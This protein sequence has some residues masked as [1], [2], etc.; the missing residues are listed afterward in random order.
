MRTQAK[1]FLKNLHSNKRI[2]WRAARVFLMFCIAISL[3]MV[4]FED[5]FIYIPAKYPEGL[6]DLAGSD[7]RGGESAFRIEDC[8][9]T[10]AD[11]V[12]L[13]GWYCTPPPP[14]DAETEAVLLWFH[15][16]AGNITYRYGMLAMLMKLPVSIFIVDYRGYG[17][18]EGSP[19]EAGLYLDATAAWDYLVNDRRVPPDRIIIFGKSLGGAIAVDLATRVQPAGLII[20]SS[21]TSVSDVAETIIPLLPRVLLRTKMDSINKVGR[22]RCPK[23]FIHSRADEVIP[24]R[25]GRHLYEAAPE[26]KRFYEVPG[27]PHNST[28]IV[29]GKAYLDTLGEFVRSCTASTSR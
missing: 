22:V 15:G 10:A 28:Y 17:K 4:L 18:S 21:F 26:P 8:Y 24:F 3:I 19:S 20:Q 5:K 12:K 1:R 13:H 2:G 16:N 25:L 11:G 29:G 6:W 7:S 14:K 27:A 9:F 23:L